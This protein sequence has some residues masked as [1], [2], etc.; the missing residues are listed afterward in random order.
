MEDDAAI[1]TN[2][3][4]GVEHSRASGVTMRSAPKSH[5]R[6]GLVVGRR[7]HALRAGVVPDVDARGAGQDRV[8]ERAGIAEIFAASKYPRQHWRG[9]RRPIEHAAARPQLRI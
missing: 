5:A 2:R 1:R 8:R 4:Q 9:I 7:A 3:L 6:V